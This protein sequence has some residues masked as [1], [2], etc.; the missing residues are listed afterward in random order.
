MHKKIYTLEQATQ[1]MSDA[2]IYKMPFNQLI[3]IKLMRLEMDFVQLALDNKA[4]LIG[5]FSQQILH[6][7]VIAAILDV[8]GGMVC[9]NQL[10]TRIEPLSHE[11][12]I[13][14]MSRMGTIDLRVDYLR[15]GR[16]NKFI[17]SANILRNGNK[18]SVTRSE[19]HNDKNQHIAS[20]TATY[21]VG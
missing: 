13:D 1:L 10:L 18:I 3:G 2:F 8:A 21:L 17:A 9:I 11:M 6:G 5:N 15:P 19:L 20:A 12:I 16:G 4:E 14:R 7:G